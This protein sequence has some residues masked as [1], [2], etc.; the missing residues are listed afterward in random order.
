MTLQEYW[1]KTIT[2]GE[3]PYLLL[4][5]RRFVVRETIDQALQIRFDQM[6]QRIRK[7]TKGVWRRYLSLAHLKDLD[8]ATT[9]FID[10]RLILN[11]KPDHVNIVGFTLFSAQTYA[12][13]FAA[14]YLHEKYGKDFP[15]LFLFGGVCVSLPDV[16]AV[17][18]KAGVPGYFVIGE[19]ERKLEQI[20]RIAQR[21]DQHG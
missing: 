19:G 6:M 11:L 9:H 15:I 17:L 4:F 18:K 5:L 20:V 10:K 7:E 1:S 21:P 13:I 14:K 3:C 2:L 16:N 12:S 8:M